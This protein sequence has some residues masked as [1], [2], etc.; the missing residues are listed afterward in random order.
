MASPSE[1]EAEAWSAEAQAW[2]ETPASAPPEATPRSAVSEATF[3]A[4]TTS[5]AANEAAASSHGGEA[6]S[7]QGGEA[8]PSAPEASW[9]PPA[10]APPPPS[11]VPMFAPPSDERPEPVEP[12]ARSTVPAVK[13][14]PRPGPSRAVIGVVVL[15]AAAGGLAI[16]AGVGSGQR[17]TADNT[18]SKGSTAPV[19]VPVA[20]DLSHVE[21]LAAVAETPADLATAVAAKLPT[22]EPEPAHTTPSKAQPTPTANPPTANPVPAKPTANGAGGGFEVVTTPAGA[23][24]FVDGEAQGTTPAQ[25]TVAPGKHKL[26]IAAEGQKL[27]KRELTF[28]PGERLE[29][30]LE[31]AKLPPEV[32]GGEGLKVRCKSRGEL[33]VYVDGADSGRTCPNEDRISVSAGVHKIGLYS[34]RSDE[35][36]EVEHEIAQGNN[37]TRVYV[38]Y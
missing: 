34:P 7:S 36:H 26:V 25:L 16:W 8:A 28:V 12:P 27:V 2:S 21:D 19:A 14:P 30:V 13:L 24:V 9:T 38:K 6:A 33:R 32:A 11:P 23:A 15:L 37:S 29:L 22:T 35:M 3:E 4:E 17:S 10:I 18:A 31:P 1:A 20:N 5:V